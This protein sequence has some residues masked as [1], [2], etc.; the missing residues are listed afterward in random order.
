MTSSARDTN[1]KPLFYESGA[2]WY[3]VLAGP[4][5]AVSMILIE[6][7]SGAGVGLL[8]PAI[9]LVMVSLFLALTG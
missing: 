8:V 2:S 6:V 9:F 5:S 7:W 1:P 3:W 4:L